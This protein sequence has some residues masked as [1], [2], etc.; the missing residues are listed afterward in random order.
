MSKTLYLAISLEGQGLSGPEAYEVRSALEDQIDDSGL[1]EVVGGGCATDG[2]AVDIDI[3]TDDFDALE[4]FLRDLL[5]HA[6]L[7]EASSFQR[8]EEA[9][10]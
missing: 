8:A 1:G 7:L 9:E 5:G 10:E 4:E 2:S 3:E 6:E